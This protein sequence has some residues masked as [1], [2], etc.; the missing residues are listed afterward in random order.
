MLSW[1]ERKA[2]KVYGVEL[3]ADA[4]LLSNL[5]SGVNFTWMEG[6]VKSDEGKWDAYMSN[7]SIPAPKLALYINYE[8]LRNTYVNLQ[9]VEIFESTSALAARSVRPRSKMENP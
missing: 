8:P 5:K 3:S 4:R 2:Q 6:K 9:Y 7:I 1:S